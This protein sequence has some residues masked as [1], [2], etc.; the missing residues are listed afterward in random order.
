MKEGKH[1]A[2][3]KTFPVASAI[4]NHSQKPYYDS[5]LY[6]FEYKQSIENSDEF[7]NNKA[8]ELI[9]WHHPYRKVSSG[10]FKDG[11]VSWFHDG[12]LN[13]SYNCIDRH[14]LVNP[15]KVAI[16]W[17]SDEPDVSKNITYKQLLEEVSKL[18]NVLIKYGVKKGDNVA[19]YMPMVPEAVYSMLAC[20]RIGAV[21]SVIFAGFSSD[22][23]RD[24]I[25]D[26]SCKILITADQGRRGGKSIHL[27]KIS[28]EALKQ[29]TSIQK[30]IVF[31]R[32]GDKSVP[33][34]TDTDVWMHEETAMQQ[35]I[36][37]PE[38]M[39]SEDPLFML[40][41]SG[42]T[43]KP[44]GVVHTT[45]GYLLGATMT[46]KYVFDY[47]E[48][49]IFGCMADVGWITGHSYIVY[50]PLSLGATTVLFESIPT[51][52]NPSRYWHLVDKHKITQFYTA[53]T[54]IRAL[55]RLGD[56]HVSSFDLSSL[57]VL[58]SVGEPIGTE[59]WLWYHNVVG[60]GKC[61][62]VDTYWQT[63]TG[64]IIVTP[65]PGATLTK[66]GSASFPFFGVELAILHPETGKELEGNDVTGV[67]AV[68]KPFPSIAR[69][70]Y[71]NHQRYLDTYFKPYGGYYFT[72]D[73][74]S[75]DKD[76][77]V[78]ILGRVD[79][80]INVSGHR[81]STAE[82]ESALVLHESCA[83]AA[84]VAIPDDIS[85]EAIVCF[86][87]LKVENSNEEELKKNLK[88]QVRQVIGPFA[89][90]KLII[91]TN[92]LP[93]TRSGKIMRRI[94]RKIAA[95][96]VDVNDSEEV[97]RSKL[98]DLS[99]LA[100]PSVIREHIGSE[101]VS[102]CRKVNPGVVIKRARFSVLQGPQ[103]RQAFANPVDLDWNQAKSV[104]GRMELDLRI[105]A[106]FTKMQT[107][108]LQSNFD[109]LKNK[110]LSFGPCQFPTLGF[111][112]NQYK[113]VENFVPEEFWYISVSLN[114]DETLA[115]FSWTK[116][117]LFDQQI[118]LVLYERCVENPSA[119]LE[120]VSSILKENGVLCHLLQLNCKRM[121]PLNYDFLLIVLC[122]AENLYNKGYL[123]Y[124][125]RFDLQSLI[126]IQCRSLQL[127]D[128]ARSLQKG[129]IRTPRK[130]Q[131][132]DKS[133]LLF[134]QP[135]VKVSLMKNSAFM[136]L[137]QGIS[138][139]CS[140]NAN[141]LETVVTIRIADE[142]FFAT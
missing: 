40:Y 19:I 64:S 39:G 71:K 123:S 12:Q 105:G 32:T 95:K 111:V 36:C 10:S 63:E 132:N 53:P 130:G 126:N 49:D 31:Q 69:T 58:G 81:L 124:P 96:D 113:K 14:A 115:K 87:T 85:G 29:C 118:W 60:K 128:Y 41:T 91:I 99:T 35:P 114:K 22:A 21:H 30:V 78:W 122:I 52:P 138:C 61:A 116:N 103:I 76:G 79:D 11:D 117:H 90:P 142:I 94:L 28:D 70:V 62:I 23:L 4:L 119:K 135:K 26:A 97:L 104:E 100:D 106:S 125:S 73:G 108:K 86:C 8:K 38:L 80:V 89:T 7:W 75:R 6:K 33:F 72:G 137:F 110:V 42:S 129:K 54:A 112:V 109:M 44:K 131:P 1:E 88:Q 121:L 45:A 140:E 50:G 37:S 18:A 3:E 74:A 24:R 127:R 34:N 59:A 48:G 98:G 141:G 56:E 136:N 68:K 9:H 92:D 65:L 15:E 134:I 83:E 57:K 82:I 5:D 17:E 20:T 84:V 107:K 25:N 101:I 77:Y 120:T 67:L 66:P 102:V 27:K 46:V 43:G 133:H 2:S 139:C 13:V 16:I 47:H 51:Y 93:K 55:R